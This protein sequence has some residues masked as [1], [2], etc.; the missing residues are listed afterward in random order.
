MELMKDVTVKTYVVLTLT[1]FGS[2]FSTALL[3][4]DAY[5]TKVVTLEKDLNT[6]NEELVK[7]TDKYDVAMMNNNIPI[8]TVIKDAQ[9]NC[10]TDTY[11]RFSN[12]PE[13]TV[14]Q[15]PLEDRAR[16]KALNKID[17]FQDQ[18]GDW[19]FDKSS[20]VNMEEYDKTHK[21]N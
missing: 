15:L 16:C 12:E 2:I 1:V 20:G 17:L 9:F 4:R 5:I 7:M 19:Y 6:S 11:M 14:D 21:G 8:G 13:L 3:V 10:A 18:N